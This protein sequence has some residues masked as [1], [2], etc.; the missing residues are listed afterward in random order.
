[1]AHKVGVEI[2][3]D[4]GQCFRNKLRDPVVVGDG[5]AD[6]LSFGFQYGKEAIEDGM[7]KVVD[8]VAVE[9]IDKGCFKFGIEGIPLVSSIFAAATSNGE[10]KY[11]EIV[12]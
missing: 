11:I 5:V 3:L 8:S 12:L 7:R 10:I 2:W 4:T 9:M 1:V 6:C